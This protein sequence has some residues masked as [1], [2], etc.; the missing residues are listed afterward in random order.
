MFFKYLPAVVWAAVIMVVSLM[1]GRH[2]PV[3][4]IWGFIPADKLGHFAVYFLLEVLM[5]WPLRLQYKSRQ[6]RS[7]PGVRTVIAGILY[8]IMV[9]I[10]QELF[11]T[12]RAF[13]IGDIAANSL[14]TA[15][16][17]AG[18]IYAYYHI[19]KKN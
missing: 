3:L 9:E 1:P 19:L 14:G 11:E 4:L 13:E 10:L 16:G 6:L 12:N 7:T 5:L 18:F 15:T 17:L 8:G 2:L